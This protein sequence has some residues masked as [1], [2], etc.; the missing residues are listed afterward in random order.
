MSNT[1]IG[2]T[3]TI[4]FAEP[5]DERGMA[6]CWHVDFIQGRSSPGVCAAVPDLCYAPEHDPHEIISVVLDHLAIY[7]DGGC[8]SMAQ[9]S[10]IRTHDGKT[11]FVNAIE[12]AGYKRLRNDDDLQEKIDGQ[13]GRGGLR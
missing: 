3:Q 13:L 9:A 7:V 5:P 10:D 6:Y 2:T 11:H 12:L 8:V 4:R 1:A